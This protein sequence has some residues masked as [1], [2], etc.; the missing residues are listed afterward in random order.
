M[1]MTLADAKNITQDKL[2]QMVI[3]EFRRDRL[4][5]MMVFD[6]TV[7]PN[8][9]SLAYVYNRV[10]T[11]PTAAPRGINSEY[12]PQEAKTTQYTVNLKPFGGAFETDRVLQNHVKGAG[13]TQISFQLEQ[14]I[15][16][17]KALFSDLFLNGDTATDS[18]AFD[19]LDKALA[20]SSTESNPTAAIDLTDANFA[21]NFKVFMRELDRMLVKLDGTPSTLLM[22]REM[23]A[24]MNAVAR[25]SRYFTQSEDAFGRPVMKYA[26]IPIVELGDKPGTANPIIPTTAG[27]TAIYAVRIGL[28]GVHALSP[29]G[30][31]IVKTYMP[32][33]TAPGTVKKGE[34]E[35]VSAM[36]LKATRAAGV[37]RKIKIA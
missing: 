11:L 34:V 23:G 31:N 6:D 29:D 12:T 9:Q 4:L 20:G 35:M 7:V 26:G 22:N 33:M 8:G 21:T 30:S 15:K 25:E 24:V 36:A 13:Y 28:D 3:D 16:A 10:T 17:T 1:A 18:K 14:K 19:G 27:E 32:D 2:A 5:D 37:L